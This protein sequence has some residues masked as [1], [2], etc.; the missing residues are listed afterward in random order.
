L[1]ATYHE[2]FIWR[3]ILFAR[4]AVSRVVSRRQPFVRRRQPF[5]SCG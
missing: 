2:R 5:V 4:G 3:R 1:S